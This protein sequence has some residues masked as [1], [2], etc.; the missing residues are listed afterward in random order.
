MKQIL[1]KDFLRR[2]I[3]KGSK[4]KKTAVEGLVASV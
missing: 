1:K 3:Y 2:T 4:V